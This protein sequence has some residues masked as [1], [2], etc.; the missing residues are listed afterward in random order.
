MPPNADQPIRSRHVS[1][2][3]A[4][5]EAISTKLEGLEELLAEDPGSEI[6][7]FFAGTAPLR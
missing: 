3:I 1:R 7:Q 6:V 4:E 5:P 2:D